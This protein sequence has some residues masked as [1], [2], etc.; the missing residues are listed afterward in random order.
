MWIWA[1]SWS[2]NQ[3]HFAAWY[4]VFSIGIILVYSILKY[5]K[6]A[7][8]ALIVVHFLSFFQ[9][10]FF[11]RIHARFLMCI[12]IQVNSILWTRRSYCLQYVPIKQCFFNQTISLLWC[13]WTIGIL[14]VGVI[15]FGTT[16]MMFR[17]SNQSTE[18]TVHKKHHTF[19]IGCIFDTAMN[20]AINTVYWFDVS[21]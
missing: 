2:I 20:I 11:L 19:L 4:I 14:R 9:M 18:S 17:P 15:G 10:Y 1:I 7:I 6:A 13:V 5:V 3:N 21:A 16:D 12:W 8:L